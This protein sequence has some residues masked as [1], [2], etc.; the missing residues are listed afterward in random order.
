MANTPGFIA[1]VQE[2]MRGAGGVS[3]RRMFGGHGVYVDGLIVGIVIDDT[4]YLKTDDT[5]RPAFVARD[6]APFLYASKR[7]PAVA[8]S[9]FAPPEEA[10]ESSAAMRE[11]L[12]LALAASRRAAARADARPRAPRRAK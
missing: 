10:L 2:L 12:R 1:H 5:T 6:L 3:A 8:T 9:Y 11:W 7:R 4:L